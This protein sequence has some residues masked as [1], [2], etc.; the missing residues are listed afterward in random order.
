MFVQSQSWVNSTNNKFAF[1]NANQG[2]IVAFSSE[3]FLKNDSF[4]NN[5]S[6]LQSANIIAEG[7]YVTINKCVFRNSVLFTSSEFNLGGFIYI[8]YSISTK[9]S[10]TLFEKGK[11]L[12]G[13]CL[14]LGI[15]AKVE[16][17]DS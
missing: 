10:S 14:F 12:Q 1:N 16:I 15:Q 17:Q 5:Y 13:G 6:F 8:S 7:S 11:A 2:T 4:Y 3:F 9:I